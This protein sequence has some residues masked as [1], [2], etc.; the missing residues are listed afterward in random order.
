MNKTRI[1][2]KIQPDQFQIALLLVGLLPAAIPVGAR[3]PARG[4]PTPFCLSTKQGTQHIFSSAYIAR[5]TAKNSVTWTRSI[6]NS[7]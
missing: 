1:M 5:P 2:L 7:T 6:K 3:H 4:Q